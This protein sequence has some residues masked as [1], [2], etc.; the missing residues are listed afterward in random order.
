MMMMIT[1]GNFIWEEREFES[2]QYMS[3]KEIV[4]IKSYEID[5]V[6]VKFCYSFYE[7]TSF[8]SNFNILSQRSRPSSWNIKKS[9]NRKQCNHR[10]HGIHSRIISSLDFSFNFVSN[11]NCQ[12][13]F[14][15]Q[16]LLH[17][18]SIAII[19]KIHLKQKK[20]FVNEKWEI[21]FSFRCNYRMMIWNGKKKLG[22]KM[23][24]DKKKERKR[25]ISALIIMILE[26]IDDE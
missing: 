5:F 12:N 24:N 14:L 26:K 9:Q 16:Y 11:F 22:N 15:I 23:G 19:G 18:Y 20:F 8:V 17:I 1:L 4:I 10:I 3:N 25:K 2:T 21:S 6:V 7:L 13:E